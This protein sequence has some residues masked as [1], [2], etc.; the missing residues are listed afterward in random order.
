MTCT[1]PHRH[2]A[3]AVIF[4][5][6]IKGLAVVLRGESVPA[7]QIA[8]NLVSKA[9]GRAAGLLATVLRHLAPW[10]APSCGL[11][12]SLFAGIALLIGGYIYA[13]RVLDEVRPGPSVWCTPRGTSQQHHSTCRSNACGTCCHLQM[14]RE[15]A[16]EQARLRAGG[17]P[18]PPHGAPFPV[19]VHAVPLPLPP[20]ALATSYPL[21]AQGVKAGLE[22]PAADAPS[23]S[24][25]SSPLVGATAQRQQEG[26]EGGRASSGQRP[27]GALLPPLG[28]ASQRV[29]ARPL[30]E[31]A[32]GERADADVERGR[33]SPPPLQGVASGGAGQLSEHRRG[34][35]QLPGQ[36]TTQEGDL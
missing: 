32:R 6:N 14:E 13:K 26:G 33:L 3:Q 10:S 8:V 1:A 16:A 7:A 35:L 22:R 25:P 11:Q 9:R 31:S 5:R 36:L 20:A 19:V 30:A 24:R 34:E 23:S 12:V 21:L 17:A 27:H 4:G 15:A 29:A 18:P 2:V 28:L